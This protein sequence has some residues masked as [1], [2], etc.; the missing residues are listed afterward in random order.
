MFKLTVLVELAFERDLPTSSPKRGDCI[1]YI[2]F[3]S[4]IPVVVFSSKLENLEFKEW[5]ELSNLRFKPN[6]MFKT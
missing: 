1:R 3:L 2:G 6:K 4:F 5:C